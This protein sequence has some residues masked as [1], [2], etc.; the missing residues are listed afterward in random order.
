MQAIINDTLTIDATSVVNTTFYEAPGRE[1]LLI[2]VSL[3][4][5]D[6]IAE[7][8]ANLG[9]FQGSDCSIRV[10]DEEAE[11]DLEYTDFTLDNMSD[12]IEKTGRMIAIFFHKTM[13]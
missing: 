1:E 10:V 13:E 3:A 5:V 9:A 12:T 8:R 7:I 2:N 11:M 6:A 4:P